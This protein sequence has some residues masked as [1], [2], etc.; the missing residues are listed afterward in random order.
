MPL[1]HHTETALMLVLGILLALTGFA[2]GLL[3]AFPA[4][5]AYWCIVFAVTVVYPL[6]LTHT[7]RSNRAD[8]EFRILHWLPAAMAAL[9]L[10]L[11]LLSYRFSVAHTVQLGFFSFWSLPLVALGIVLTIAFAA[12]VIRR[13]NVR[14]PFLA[15]LL[16][17]FAAASVASHAMHWNP[18]LQAA[19]FPQTDISRIAANG[20]RSVTG[21]LAAVRMPGSTDATSSSASIAAGA[22]SAMSAASES[23]SSASAK[24]STL[25]SSAAT[26]SDATTTI[27]DVLNGTK[28]RRL[29]KTGPEETAAALL[30]AVL[31]GYC[32][33]LHARA[34]R[35][36]AV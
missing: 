10:L 16:T 5:I 8:Y 32:G 12:H 35:R 34:R 30:A 31:A 33:V 26:S 9:W 11:E 36:C 23:M 2:L 4:G 28:P 13:R 24:R 20:Y 21:L 6:L 25:S 14:I 3:P 1:K 15:V 17:V 29:T 18:V 7:L 27:A 22:S 19:L